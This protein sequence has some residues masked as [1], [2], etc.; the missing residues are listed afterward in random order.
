MLT[1]EQPPLLVVQEVPDA[2]IFTAAHALRL[3]QNGEIPAT[4]GELRQMLQAQ[5]AL[6]VEPDDL[7]ALENELPYHIEIRPANTAGCFEVLFRH[8]S[9]P[10]G[11]QIA[12][13]SEYKPYDRYA[14]NPTRAKLAQNVVPLYRNLAAENLPD[15]MVP[16]AFV[17]L[18][19][20]PLTP[21]GKVD[22]K[23]LPSPDKNRAA[24]QA[25]FVA[26]RNELEEIVA[27]VWSQVLGIEQISVHD[28]FFE[29]GGHSLL[30]TQVV[31]RLRD[32]LEIE[33]SLQRLFEAMT[34]AQ[35]AEVIEA[36]FVAEYESLSEEEVAQYLEDDEQ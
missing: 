16:S 17:I 14:T 23:A 32:A 1:D 21:N 18:D 11:V 20:L 28:N 5:N 12:H 13:Q 19:E 26:P 30:A 9:L 35:I 15:Y 29:L 33:L 36:I 25:E 7:Y 2:R 24:S 22:R 6:A 3:A 10:A 27:D 8:H 4:V 34:I 31:S